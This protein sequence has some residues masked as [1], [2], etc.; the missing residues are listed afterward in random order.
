MAS[1]DRD[2]RRAE[3]ALATQECRAPTVKCIF[4]MRPIADGAVRLDFFEFGGDLD[5]I[6]VGIMDEHEQIVAR[7]MPPGTPFQ[8]DA[9][10]GEIISP[11]ADQVPFLRLIA[12]VI[13]A[14]PIGGEYRKTVMFV[15]ATHEGGA[16][17]ALLVH[18]S[19]AQGEAD[20]VG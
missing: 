13:E 1:D 10:L 5:P 17:P 15:A 4:L 11:V 7:T 14:I 3:T 20:Y 2:S 6:I 18:Y 12:V 19:I 16:Q 9:L 8:R